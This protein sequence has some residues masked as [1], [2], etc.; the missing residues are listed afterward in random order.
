ML[1]CYLDT[2][3]DGMP[4]LVDPDDDND[5]YNDTGDEFPLDPTEWVDTDG[6][7]VGDNAD[8][9]DDGDSWTDIEEAISCG[10]SDLLLA[11]STPSTPTAT[12][13]ATPWTP[14]TTTTSSPM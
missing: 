9:D 8:P 12:G 2:D 4:D 5:G 13:C 11:S 14:T 6:D 7:G 1:D 3:L 10:D